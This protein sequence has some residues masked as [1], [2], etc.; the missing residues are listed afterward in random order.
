MFCRYIELRLVKMLLKKTYIWSK[1]IQFTL[2]SSYILQLGDDI[3][4][5]DRPIFSESIILMTV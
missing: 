1:E 2:S 3:R 5:R 4:Q